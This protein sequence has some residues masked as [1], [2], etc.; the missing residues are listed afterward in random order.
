[1]KE[2]KFL[3]NTFFIEDEQAKRLAEIT[4]YEQDETTLV[5]DHTYVDEALR[6]QSIAR[7]LV[8]HV[9]AF[10]REHKKKIIPECSYAYKVLTS[11]EEYSDIIKK[12]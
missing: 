8:N 3:S 4:F 12:D 2:I 5:I 9:V 11:N 7:M 10:A 6:G 1:M